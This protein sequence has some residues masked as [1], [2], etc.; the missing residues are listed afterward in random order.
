MGKSDDVILVERTRINFGENIRSLRPL[1]RRLNLLDVLTPATNSTQ[2]G[3]WTLNQTRFPPWVGYDSGSWTSAKGLVVPGSNFGYNFTNALPYHWIVNCFIAQRGSMQWHYNWEGP[4]SVSLYAQRVPN[5]VPTISV[6]SDLYTSGTFSANANNLLL[7]RGS[8]VAGGALTNQLTNAGLS[9]SAPNYTV[10]KFQ[11]TNPTQGT[12]AVGTG[13][14]YDG[15]VFDTFQFK[16]SWDGP[17]A[18]LSKGRLERYVG[19][20]TDFTVHFFLNCPTTYYYDQTAVVP[21]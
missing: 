20:G 21:N 14:A 11:S 5:A 9:V 8:T 15:S 18:D 2:R 13:G 1:L 4:D 7:A 16:V 6:V 3:C 12:T 19:V 10:F 17:T